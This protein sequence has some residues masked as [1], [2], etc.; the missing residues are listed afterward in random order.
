MGRRRGR[1]GERRK[2]GNGMEEEGRG[3]KGNKGRMERGGEVKAMRGGEK[4]WEGG[5]KREER[6]RERVH[7]L[8]KTTN[9][10]QMAGYR[11]QI[12]LC[13]PNF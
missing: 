7:N 2:K 11:L 12:F 9:R 10:H 5:K 3:K 8:R 6:A 1:D 13:A 4:G